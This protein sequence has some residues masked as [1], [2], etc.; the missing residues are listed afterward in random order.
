[1]SHLTQAQDAQPSKS[2][3]ALGLTVVA[4]LGFLISGC[5]SV[6][7][8]ESALASSSNPNAY[9]M[10]S[11]SI[12]AWGVATTNS[13]SYYTSTSADVD[14][15]IRDGSIVWGSRVYLLSGLTSV[16]PA[17]SGMARIW[18]E[19]D[20]VEMRSVSD[21]TWK[22]RRSAV[23]VE[24]GKTPAY[25]TVS[26]IIKVVTPMGEERF[27]KPSSGD[28]YLNATFD[29]SA[30]ECRR[31]GRQPVMKSMKLKAMKD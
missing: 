14:I 26:F 7:S 29:L 4:A 9:R 21:F 17:H 28:S 25:D 31:E 3:L 19:K 8:E 11:S 13:C 30:A 2:K 18:D 22:A 12:E 15:T 10:G 1:M 23:L 16:K 6:R 20:E 24:R 5:G 27:I